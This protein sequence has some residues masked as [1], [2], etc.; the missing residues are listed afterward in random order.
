MVKNKDKKEEEPEPIKE[1]MSDKDFDKAV[2]EFERLGLAAMRFRE[3]K[4]ELDAREAELKGA[5]KRQKEAENARMSADTQVLAAQAELKNLQNSIHLVNERLTKDKNDA[6]E[7]FDSFVAGI[8][9]EEKA[10]NA[11]FK[12]RQDEHKAAVDA[13]VVQEAEAQKKHDA[14]VKSHEKWKKDHGLA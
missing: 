1:P 4:V 7:A 6:R 2:G 3:I 14:L 8:K 10:I 11:A 12:K 5:E 9:A 13:F